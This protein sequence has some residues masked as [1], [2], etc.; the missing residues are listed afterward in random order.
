MSDTA[1]TLMTHFCSELQSVDLPT[2]K[3]LFKAVKLTREKRV[4]STQYSKLRSMVVVLDE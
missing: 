1:A 3:A 4:R 2:S